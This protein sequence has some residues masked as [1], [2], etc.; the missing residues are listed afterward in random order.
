MA[1]NFLGYKVEARSAATV[2]ADIAAQLD[3][4][5]VNC[6]WMACLNPHSY[7]IAKD[8]TVFATALQNANWLVPDGIGVVIASR[9]LKRPLTERITGFDIFD[10]VMQH[11]NRRGGSV[12]FLG[13]THDTLKRIAE[14]LPKDYPN[15]TLAGTASPP[16]KINYTTA[17]IDNMVNAINDAQPDVLW[18]GLTAPKQEKLIADLQPRLNVSFAGAIGAVFDFYSGK[19]KRSPILFRNAGLEWLPRLIQQPRRLWRRMGVSAPIF[20]CD[21]FVRFISEKKGQ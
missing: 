5:A 2:V 16:F 4:G 10:G 19:I 12:F 9:I 1:H 15:V 13:S 7:V 17:E 14:K 6:T 20:I 21:V 18:V 3:I 8:D 11:L